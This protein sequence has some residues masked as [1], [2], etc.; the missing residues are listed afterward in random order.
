MISRVCPRRF[1][2]KP[3]INSCGFRGFTQAASNV[4]I[5][6]AVVGSGP[7]AF[8]T[9][10]HLLQKHSVGVK[11]NIDIF[12][13]N[14]VP[15]GLSR[16]GVAP[17]HPEVK[18]CEEKFTEILEDTG[19]LNNNGSTE[20]KVSFFGNLEIGKDVSL[21]DL[22]KNYNIVLFAY[23]CSG[24]NGLSIP[25]A[26]SPAVISS[27]KFVGWYNGV[28]DLQDLNPPL[29]Q[30]EDVTIIGNGNVALDTTRVLLA[31]V[32]AWKETDISK[33]ALQI[34]SSSTVKRVRIVARR[35]FLQS[36]Y[37]NKELRELFELRSSGVGFNIDE[38]VLEPARLINS[39]LSR[40]AKRRL[41]LVNKYLKDNHS[42]EMDKSWTLDY[43]KSPVEV[44]PNRYNPELL[45][46]TKFQI[47]KLAVESVGDG[48]EAARAVSS[49][50]Y[51][52]LKNELLIT[53]I[54]YKGE[55]L[56]SMKDI[57]IE[58]NVRKGVIPNTNSRVLDSKKEII[59][60]VYVTGWIKHGPK[61]VIATTMMD[62][63]GTA[64]EILH[65]IDV[66][67]NQKRPGFEGI[68]NILNKANY[69]TWKDWK[70]ID[71]HERTTGEQM[72]KVR[73]KL[74]DKSQ[75]LQITKEN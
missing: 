12:E 72:G 11:L 5:Q 49:H 23:G 55:E 44:F 32:E 59:P 56:E 24:E 39:R 9:V 75:M 45:S 51:V 67:G 31:P 25:G 41:A 27:R 34:L 37:T 71:A 29:D 21:V 68:K 2:F 47:N 8:Y 14:P 22:K 53:S 13:K 66:D 4:P 20:S 16:Y 3:V 57:G 40:P 10:L 64:A 60:G 6:V 42:S 52:S 50:E 46:S 74:V 69:T 73:E 54:G 1:N 19:S 58:F 38:K 33:V 35:G 15:F 63:F 62:S 65:D 30:V 28:S 48:P 26:D 7:S 18:N 36:A 17:D 61:G 70:K 43:L